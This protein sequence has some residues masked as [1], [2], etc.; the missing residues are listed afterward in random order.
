MLF[1][2]WA[3]MVGL[4]W[5]YYQRLHLLRR[6]EDRQRFVSQ[7]HSQPDFATPVSLSMSPVT[8]LPPKPSPVFPPTS[9]A[10]STSSR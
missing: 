7:L 1:L 9:A 4:W 5:T 10:G 6:L 8:P 2:V 3:S